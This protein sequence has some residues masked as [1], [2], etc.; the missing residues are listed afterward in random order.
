[1]RNPK[2]IYE[3]V[4]GAGH[5]LGDF[6][7]FIED[8][9]DS[10][11]VERLHEVIKGD[12]NL[13]VPSFDIFQT[14]LK[15]KDGTQVLQQK[16]GSKGSTDASF[17]SSDVSASK[18]DN[19]TIEECPEGQVKDPETGA[20]VTI[21]EYSKKY[22]KELV[23]E[24]S[25][26]DKITSLKEELPSTSTKTNFKIPFKNKDDGDLF[27]KYIHYKN[28]DWAENNDFDLESEE[29]N[30]QYVQKAW[31]EFGDEYID[32]Y[33]KAVENKENLNSFLDAELKKK[34][35]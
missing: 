22:D 29:F 24:K 5:E 26:D 17:E 15:K 10:E 1:M 13:V 28:P 19:K 16:P 34:R 12:E 11:N 32:V 21:E 8:M 6:D 33:N 25:I 7:T 3:V 23:E 2:D 30:N 27:R 31:N 35:A 4:S 20:C 9:N 14:A 18:Q